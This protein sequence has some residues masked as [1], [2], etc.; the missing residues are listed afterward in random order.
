MRSDRNFI[1]FDKAYT[2][3]VATV[4]ALTYA[5]TA[6]NQYNDISYDDSPSIVEVVRASGYETYW[7]SNQSK[8]SPWS[9][10]IS[11]I[12]S[13][14]DHHVWLGETYDGELLK[15]LPTQDGKP[16]VI[17]IHLVGSHTDYPNRY[18]P[19]I[20][21]LGRAGQDECLRQFPQV[22]RL[23]AFPTL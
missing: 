13:N 10:P 20:Q 1:L 14:A 3:Y 7:L 19:G 16:T 17:F 15:H 9:T 18:P 8:I 11:I 22:Q 21:V 2:S 23:G 6:K 5:L 12:S 4:S